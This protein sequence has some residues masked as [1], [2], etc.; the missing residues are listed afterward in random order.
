MSPWCS[1]G[2]LAFSFF[3]QSAAWHVPRRHS[4]VAFLV[5]G[6]NPKLKINRVKIHPP[7]TV[8]ALD[9]PVMS[10][11]HLGRIK[12]HSIK[13]PLLTREASQQA[14]KTKQKTIELW[15]TP[16]GARRTVV[17]T[18]GLRRSAGLKLSEYLARARSGSWNRVKLPRIRTI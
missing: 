11:N 8:W 14:R 15:Q 7:Q 4:D 16:C 17:L 12:P 9:S 5:C 2:N 6:D 13:V 1:K 3:I 10:S 18:A